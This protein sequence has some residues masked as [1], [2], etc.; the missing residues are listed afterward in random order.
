MNSRCAMV[1]RKPEDRRVIKP[2][3]TKWLEQQIVQNIVPIDYE[4]CCIDILK[5]I[6]A[7]EFSGL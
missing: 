5:K 2:T 3:L 6:K 7:G 4:I 1:D